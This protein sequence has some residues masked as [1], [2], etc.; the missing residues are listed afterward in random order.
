MIAHD[1][2]IPFFERE[3]GSLLEVHPIQVET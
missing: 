3:L 2:P 1:S